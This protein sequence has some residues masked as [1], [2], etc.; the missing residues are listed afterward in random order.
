M[1][2]PVASDTGPATPW[3][4]GIRLHM[5]Q[6]ILDGKVCVPETRLEETIKSHHRYMGHVGVKR[7]VN[8]LSRRYVWP[9]TPPSRKKNNE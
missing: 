2:G 1:V 7:L 6:M 3:P 4:P 5:R 8:D 9:E